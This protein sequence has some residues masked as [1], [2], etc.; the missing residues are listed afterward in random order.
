MHR[1]SAEEI[2]QENQ[3]IVFATARRWSKENNFLDLVQEGNVGLLEAINHFDPEKSDNFRN[4]AGYWVRRYI[5]SYVMKDKPVNVP[6]YRQEE[7]NR[8]KNRHRKISALFGY[9]MQKESNV[10]VFRVSL[11]EEASHMSYSP[12]ANEDVQDVMQATKHLTWAEVIVLRGRYVEGKT[13]ADIGRVVGKTRERIRQI[14]E[15]AIDKIRKKL[16]V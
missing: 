3:D 2:I 11:D 5:R 15:G 9:T 1:K 4:Y 12:S 14:E 8:E 7:S 10:D 13:L 16:K 6:A